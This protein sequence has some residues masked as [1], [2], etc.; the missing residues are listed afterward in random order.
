MKRKELS[1]DKLNC[2]IKS[3]APGSKEFILHSSDHFDMRIQCD[4][5]DAFLDLL[6]LRF[7]H[8][9]SDVTLKVYGVPQPGLKEFHVTPNRRS[10][11]E[12]LPPDE[13]RLHDEEIQS[14]DEYE[15]QTQQK[16]MASGKGGKPAAAGKSSKEESKDGMS[17]ASD[18]DTEG[19][20]DFMAPTGRQEGGKKSFDPHSMGDEDKVR[21][22]GTSIIIINLIGN[23]NVYSR[24]IQKEQGR[25]A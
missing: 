22:H 23:E 4:R 18:T 14:R 12:H 7:A 16:Q 13:Y 20:F 24:G 10:G 8:M 15:K 9:K 25:E 11:M 6:K 19:S 2:V 21:K 3:K 5:R 17:S 1:I